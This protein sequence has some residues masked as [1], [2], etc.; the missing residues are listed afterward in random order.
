MISRLLQA[1][2]EAVDIAGVCAAAGVG[3]VLRTPVGFVAGER[4]A[5]RAGALF[6]LGGELGHT[7]FRLRLIS[8]PLRPASFAH[9]EPLV[10]RLSFPLFCAAFP[11]SAEIARLC[12]GDIEAN[13]FLLLL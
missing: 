3:A 6:H 9:F 13:P 11:P 1:T 10:K 2:E 8:P 12:S 7:A 5:T 4:F